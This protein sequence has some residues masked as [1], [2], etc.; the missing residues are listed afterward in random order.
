MRVS[1]ISEIPLTHMEIYRTL[2]KNAGQKPNEGTCFFWFKM[3]TSRLTLAANVLYTIDTPIL[4][5]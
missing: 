2:V 4:T 5:D 1:A 3:F